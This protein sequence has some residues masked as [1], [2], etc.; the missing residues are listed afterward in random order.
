MNNNVNKTTV[1]QLIEDASSKEYGIAASELT[2]TQM[3]RCVATVVRD[4]LLEKRK[5]FNKLYK[6]KDRKRI[7]YLSMEFLL[8]RS[9]KNNLYNMGLT[10]V[11]SEALARYK[12]KL[13]D[14]YEQEPDAG[15]G[16]GG[17][18]R[19]A[20]CYLD[21]LATGDYPSMGHS[22]RFEYGLFQQKLVNGWQTEL[23]DNWLPGGEVWLKER[24]DKSVTVRFG[25]EVEEIW[26][27]NGPI[28]QQT[29][30]QEVEA[31][32]YDMVVAGYDSKAVA[33][34][35]LW[36]ARNTKKFDIHAFGQG[37]YM[38]AVEEQAQAE[39]I[40]KVLY[41]SD[42]HEEGKTLRLKQEYFLVSAAMQ[43]ITSDHYKKYGN[44]ENF[45]EMVAVHIND[46]H[47]ALAVPELMRI[48]V[49]EYSMGWDKAWSIVQGICAYTNHTVLAEALECW[50]EYIFKKVLPRIYQIVYE[51][52]ERACRGYWDKVHDWNKVSELAVVAYG[53]VR[54]ANLSIVGSHSVNGVSQLHSDIIKKTLFKEFYEAEP[55]K[56]GNVTNGIAHRRWLCQSNPRLTALIKELIGD[57]FVKDASQLS[58]LNKFIDDGE[59][60]KRL[61]K[62]KLAN[63]KDFAD[64]V[65]RKS[66]IKIDPNTRFDV[67]VKRLHEYKRQL[68][69]VLKIIS[70]YHD[71]RENPDADIT[72][73]TFIFGAKA[74]PSYFA[75]KEVIKLIYMI[76]KDLERNPKIREKLNVVFM[77][78]YCVTMAEQLMPAS[79]ISQQ[80]SLAGKEASGTGNMKFMINGAVTVGTLDGANVEMREA[81]GD[82]NIFIFGMKAKEVADTWAKG[83]SSTDYYFK[84]PKL[85]L[86]VE[87]LN[88]GFGGE[89]FENISNYLLR[90]NQVADPYM[91]FADFAAYVSACAKMDEAYRDPDRWNRM[92]LKNIAESG[93]FAADRA[94][95]EYA[96]KIWRM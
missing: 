41:P 36:S 96:E 48:F 20:A 78:N 25:G 90:S 51:I 7:H 9:L 37:E 29:D 46:T 82:D 12:F 63:K 75:A 42:N 53:Q 21:G 59:V 2:V 24:P 39:L 87:D 35:R 60:L 47:P 72:P 43:N 5:T 18:G 16:N 4:M 3:Y 70:I 77:E 67:Q 57:G 44:F 15:L 19:L 65:L 50:P 34:L 81:V 89:T 52:N 83:Y 32:P 17:L 55:D 45:G 80:I 69:N 68:L 73:Q 33:V 8:G 56:F 26:T 95:K 40:T 49:D 38:R 74:A 23:P 94:V 85:R 30:C 86:I 1:K 11:F 93:R 88:R 22:L 54:M 10:E 71:L 28:Y 66:G 62:I 31:F 79:E 27:Q 84:N 76:S 58:K 91:C 92:S 64:T 6:A 14:L 61:P 13:T